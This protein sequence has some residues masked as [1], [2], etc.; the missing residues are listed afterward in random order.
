MQEKH[1]F[2][3]GNEPKNKHEHLVCHSL[4][5][6]CVPELLC[7]YT[8]NRRGAGVESKSITKIFIDIIR[9]LSRLPLSVASYYL[10]KN[11]PGIAVAGGKNL[12]NKNQLLNYILLSGTHN[13][14]PALSAAHDRDS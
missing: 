14:A 12:W 6:L 5:H 9:K 13:P 8:F 10:N 1:A 2:L 4:Q 3:F 11:P 7:E